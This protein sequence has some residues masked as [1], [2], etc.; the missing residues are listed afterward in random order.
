MTALLWIVQ[1][2][3]AA[4]W[5]TIAIKNRFSLYKSVACEPFLIFHENCSCSLG[6]GAFNMLCPVRKTP[7]TIFFF[8]FRGTGIV[9]TV[10]KS[11]DM[12]HLP[13]GAT[14]MFRSSR[15]TNSARR[16][17]ARE[18]GA[19][20]SFGRLRF[21]ADRVIILRL[22]DMVQR[23]CAA[24]LRALMGILAGFCVLLLAGLAALAFQPALIG[25]L[26][27]SQPPEQGSDA[28]E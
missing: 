28:G 13:G 10:A 18:T 19:S 15:S 4:A 11:R 25:L 5:L 3:Q 6:A 20:A 24:L 21:W 14:P 8:A 26:A 16:A 2:Y 27:P 17:A 12:A 7:G 23:S 22:M 9:R 1:C